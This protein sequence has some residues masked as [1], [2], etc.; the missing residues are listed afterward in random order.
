[1]TLTQVFDKSVIG[2]DNNRP[3]RTTLPWTI[4]LHCYFWVKMVYI[5]T[6]HTIQEFFDNWIF[7]IALESIW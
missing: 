6:N 3:F 2:T 5:L 1:M 4:R 7:I